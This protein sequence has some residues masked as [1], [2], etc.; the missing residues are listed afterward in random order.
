MDGEDHNSLHTT[1]NTQIIALCRAF[2][3]FY[4]T[5]SFTHLSLNRT[6]FIGGT[7]LVVDFKKV[8]FAG[9]R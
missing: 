8:F 7:K 4:L 1:L 6:E 9:K 5:T 2:E 3:L